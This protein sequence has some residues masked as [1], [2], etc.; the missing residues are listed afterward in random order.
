MFIVRTGDRDISFL[1]L[2]TIPL[3]NFTLFLQLLSFL[4]KA[5]LSIDVW[6]RKKIEVVMNENKEMMSKDLT[7]VSRTIIVVYH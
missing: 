1:A 6:G 7:P 4:E 5:S 3:I 2:L